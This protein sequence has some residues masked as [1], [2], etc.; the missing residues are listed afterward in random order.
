METN[1]DELEY[2]KNKKLT[3]RFYVGMERGVDL[4]RRGQTAYHTEYNQLYPY[5]KTFTDHQLCK[6]QY[7]DTIP[8]VKTF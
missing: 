8:E 3:S 7:V 1:W 2:L 4:I 5:L 6:L